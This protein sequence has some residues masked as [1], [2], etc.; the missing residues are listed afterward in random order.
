MMISRGYQYILKKFGPLEQETFLDSATKI[1]IIKI[2]PSE[3]AHFIMECGTGIW[4]DGRFQLCNPFTF[5]PIIELLLQGDAE[6]RP[7]RTAMLG[8][9]A[10]GKIMAWNHDH[11]LLHVDLPFL[12]ASIDPIE[13]GGTPDQTVIAALMGINDFDYGDCDEDDV[14]QESL[15]FERVR[16]AHGPLQLGEVYGFFPAL[17]LGGRAHVETA[18]RVKALEHFAILAQLGPVTLFKYS[19]GQRVPIR[20]LGPQDD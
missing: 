4:L 20:Q 10:F 3:I 18:R 13:P 11:G 16:K 14:E 17:E 2:F 19:K 1:E 5:Q 6:L 8:Y 15:L 9:S 12:W 7:D